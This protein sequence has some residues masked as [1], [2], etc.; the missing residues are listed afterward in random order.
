MF[1]N[2]STATNWW[3]IP[4]AFED[5]GYSSGGDW[6]NLTNNVHYY[7]T[8]SELRNLNPVL[9]TG[10]LNIVNLND[11]HIWVGDGLRTE[12]YWYLGYDPYDYNNDGE[13][14]DG[15]CFWTINYYFG[16]NWGWGGKGNAYYIAN[17]SFDVNDPT[18]DTY[19]KT[20]TNIRP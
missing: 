11:W 16:M 17:G 5:M 20:L 8:I 2:C 13:G 7:E 18:Y 4:D 6:G 15:D 9:F 12:K 3:N 19:I 14:G 10:T 1:G